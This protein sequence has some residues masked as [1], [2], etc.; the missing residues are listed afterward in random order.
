VLELV[1][2]QELEQEVLQV[3]LGQGDLV[4]LAVQVLA[5]DLEA[6]VPD[7]D[8]VLVPTLALDQALWETEDQALDPPPLLG[9]V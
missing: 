1:G 3:P 5:P 4:A 2:L 8:P 6:Q 9:Q 7:L